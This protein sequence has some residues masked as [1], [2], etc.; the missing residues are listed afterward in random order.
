VGDGD[1]ESKRRSVSKGAYQ[2]GA[3]WKVKGILAASS[4]TGEATGYVNFWP[5]RP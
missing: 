5:T 4:G 3:R 1:E 2:D